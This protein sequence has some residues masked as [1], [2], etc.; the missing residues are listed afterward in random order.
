MSN[1]EH[2]IEFKKG[3]E[4]NMAVFVSQL[5]REGVTFNINRDDHGYEIVLTGGY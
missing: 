4:K 3:E 1:T 2:R 5:V